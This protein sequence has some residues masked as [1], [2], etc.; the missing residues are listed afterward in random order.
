LSSNDYEQ[1]EKEEININTMNVELRDFYLDDRA[2]D[3]VE[4]AE[5]C[6]RVI[7]LSYETFKTLT[8]NEYYTNIDEVKPSSKSNIDKAYHIKEDLNQSSENVTVK[9]YWNIIKDMYV[10]IANDVLIRATPIMETINGKKALPFV[11]RQFG[12][13]M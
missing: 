7:E 9:C 5:D 10:E 4:D 13:K 8:D 11:F 6:F 1:E 12:R 3:G 2:K